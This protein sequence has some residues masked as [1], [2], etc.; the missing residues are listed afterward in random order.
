MIV[1]GIV[2]DFEGVDVLLDMDIYDG[3]DD[4]DELVGDSEYGDVDVE[5]AGTKVGIVDAFIGT[6]ELDSE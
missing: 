5:L 2:G 1:L 3:A 4:V 6:G